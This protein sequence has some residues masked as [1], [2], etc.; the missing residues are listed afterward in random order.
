MGFSSV[1]NK[2]YENEVCPKGKFRV[3]EIIVDENYFE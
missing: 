1:P 3:I 2:Y